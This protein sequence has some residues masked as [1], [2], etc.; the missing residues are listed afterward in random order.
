MRGRGRGLKKK[1]TVYSRIS[2]SIL[3]DKLSR[4]LYF[5]CWWA[6]TKNY[7]YYMVRVSKMSRKMQQVIAACISS[8]SRIALPWMVG[9]IRKGRLSVP[10][11][12]N[13]RSV[14]SCIQI[15]P[16]CAEGGCWYIRR[17]PDPILIDVD[18]RKILRIL[19][20]LERFYYQTRGHTTIRIHF[21][22]HGKCPNYFSCFYC[23]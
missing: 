23:C 20:R 18:R 14:W 8:N 1:D 12:Y 11:L 15:L 10:Q 6:C 9:T 2:K 5:W 16:H 19:S 22:S 7:Y 13:G 21:E 3:F 4:F 17:V